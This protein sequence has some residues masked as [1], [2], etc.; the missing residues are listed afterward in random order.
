MED[1][2]LQMRMW[3]HGRRGVYS[4]ELVVITDIPADRLTRSYHRRW[5]KGHGHHYARLRLEEI[6]KSEAGRLFDV[7]A[8]LYR[9]AL[10]D[11]AQ[12][13]KHWAMG[14]RDLAFIYETHLYFF[15]GFYSMR[16]R[17]FML[18]RSNNS[19]SEIASFIR[20]LARSR[21]DRGTQEEAG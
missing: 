1:L 9:Q 19:I 15:A 4:P 20:T 6:E 2:E 10:T 7:P 21:K 8:H 13:I 17:D 11:A 3:R 16:R 18:G 12:W 14:K 5:H